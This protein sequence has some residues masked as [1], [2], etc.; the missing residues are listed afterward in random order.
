MFKEKARGSLGVRR[1]VGTQTS[2]SVFFLIFSEFPLTI[3]QRNNW[4][5]ESKL[6][7]CFVAV[8]GDMKKVRVASCHE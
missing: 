5:A 4:S 2:Q 8:Q 3:A 6:R 1:A 7:P